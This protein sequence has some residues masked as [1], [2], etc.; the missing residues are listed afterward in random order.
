ME[1]TET[2]SILA[3]AVDAETERVLKGA[4]AGRGA[5]VRRGDVSEA[6]TT[7]SSAA[8][9]RLLFV[10]LD[11][12][13]FPVGRI[14]ELASVCEFGT[15]VI[16]VSSNDT[17]RFTRE[18]LACGVSDYLPKPLTVSDIHDAVTTA[19][20]DEE[21]VAAR[22]YAGRVIAFAGCG[23]SG[24]TTLAALTALTAAAQGSYVSVLDLERTSGALPLMLD[25]EPAVGFD[26]L[27]DL[28]SKAGPRPRASLTGC[29]LVSPRRASP[30]TATGRA[31]AC[32][33]RPRLRP[34][35]G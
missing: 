17:A 15:A 3:F 21:D 28:G 4:L 33:P 23:G 8:S 14:H 25:V 9:P 19:L 1:A 2:S 18:L 31:T 13:E 20:R 26:E 5:Q 24:A 34:S 32:R 7:L 16:A 22:L 10:D 35:N 27:L 11:G 29:R 12:A 30:C 6:I